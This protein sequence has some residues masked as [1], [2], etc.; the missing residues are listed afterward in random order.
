MTKIKNIMDMHD[1]AAVARGRVAYV[2]P[3][4]SDSM[5]DEL[6]KE[7]DVAKE[8][9]LAEVTQLQ[10]ELTFYK[11]RVELFQQWQNKMR[12]PERTIA[13]D[14]LANGQMLPDP[15]GKRYGI[16]GTES[17]SSFTDIVSDGGMDPRN[18]VRQVREPL[19]VQ[20]IYDLAHR[21]ATRYTHTAQ[22]S[23][24][25]YGFSETHLVDFVRAIEARDS[26]D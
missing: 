8:A 2:T 1:T 11:R 12:D 5:G 25:M 17:I 22:P 19:R 15:T 16:G 13:C 9:L 23:E 7:L 3:H 4:V 24:V 18:Q 10:D 21:K 20:V 14:I 26:G 6:Q